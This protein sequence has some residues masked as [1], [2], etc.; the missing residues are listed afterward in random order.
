MLCVLIFLTATSAALK[1]TFYNHNLTTFYQGK[2][3]LA[4]I[5]GLSKVIQAKQ[6]T[7]KRGNNQALSFCL[8]MVQYH[9]V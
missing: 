5:L 6:L 4:H 3:L 2:H 9:K 1:Y 8:S 7:G